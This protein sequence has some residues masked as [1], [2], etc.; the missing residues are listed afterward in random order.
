M[1]TV[2]IILALYLLFYSSYWLFLTIIGV[3]FGKRKKY[4]NTRSQPQLLLILPAY[5]PG[6]IFSRVLDHV[7]EAIRGRNI[8]VFVLLQD[9]GEYDPT[10]YALNKGFHVKIKSFSNRAGNSYQHALQYITHIIYDWRI[11]GRWNPDFVMLLDK[12]N[13]IEPDFFESIPS[14]LYDQYDIIQGR[15]RPLPTRTAVGFF[16]TVSEA[17]NDV[18][19]RSAKKKLGFM[20][21]ISGSG[22]LIETDI[23]LNVISKLN[24]EAPG[25]DKNF[26]AHL[27][28]E[29][30]NIRSIYWPA[31]KIFEEKT[32][33]LEAHN[34]QRLRWFGEQYYNAL[35]H[36]R[37]L[38]VSAFRYRRLAALDYLLT[39]WRPPRSLQ[40]VITPMLALAELIGY[41]LTHTWYF[42]FPLLTISAIC[43]GLA[44]LVFLITEK[45]LWKALS[46]SLDLPRLAIHNAFNAARS[47]RKENLGKFVHTTHKL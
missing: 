28:M 22:A 44:V 13:L 11:E 15:R 4:K 46:Y 39:L 19:F 23:F 3:R 32:T 9:I 33:D 26:M 37:D 12:D 6:R 42:G 5:K 43:T 2:L 38:V 17:L 29:R 7:E 25:F 14:R 18:M 8:Q 47:I 34:P 10:A 30:R 21:E 31:S 27:L 16:D 20:V 1:K 41:F 36:A 40:V 24:P 45:L 35:Y